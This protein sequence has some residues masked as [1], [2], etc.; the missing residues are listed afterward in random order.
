MDVTK[1]S[2]YT[3]F[4]SLVWCFALAYIGF[5][6]GRNWGAVEGMLGYLTV[7]VAIGILVVF[8]YALYHRKKMVSRAR[9]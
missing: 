9:P 7:A 8:A 1:F 6:L 3:F 5:T 2:V 4:G